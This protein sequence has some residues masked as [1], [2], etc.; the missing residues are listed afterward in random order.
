MRYLEY[1]EF[2]LVR[3]S[4]A[5]RERLWAMA[6]HIIRP[7]R[8]VLPQTQSPR[9]AWMVRLGLFLY[10]HIGGRKRL[11]KTKT[12]ALS[13]AAEGDGL[14][15]RKGRGFIYSDCWVDDARLVVLN[16]V[17]AKALGARIHTRTKFLSASRDGAGWAVRLAASSGRHTV[18]ARAIVN[19]AGP[20]VS[21][22]V[23]QV[24]NAHP[25]GRVRL[26]KGSHIVVPRL[27]DGPHAYML[28]NPDRRIVF[29]IPYQDQFTLIG[30]TDVPVDEPPQRAQID[31]EEIAYLLDTANRYFTT[32]S[33]RGDIVWT[34]SG[35]RPLFDDQAANVSAVTRDYVLD[36]D[37]GRGGEACLLN[38]FGGKIT[39][40]RRLAEHAMDELG[41]AGA[42]QA[43][44]AGAT[45]PGGE[46]ADFDT[47]LADVC[48]RY[49]RFAQ[50]FLKRLARA[51]GT[52]LHTIIGDAKQIADLGE[53][54]G[55]GLTRAEVDY[56]VANEW[57]QTA[58]DILWRRSKLGL[59]VPEDT[60]D[61]LAA[62]LS[63]G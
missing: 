45:L 47:F 20:W 14:K 10:D 16:A 62:Y 46:F 60:E 25:K 57:A 59:H 21:E 27:F 9:P 63:A 31:D 35:V 51:Y 6:P 23:E 55:G 34:Y 4:L 22:V 48:D 54:F 36:L 37:R 33:G 41:L 53:D 5:E 7:M 50:S 43:W 2:R 15:D 56:L 24:E 44:T 1:G 26:I 17:D 18:E 8:F 11:P 13:S 32:Q 38:V 61:R 39:T 19:T 40:F 52:R 3:E 58:Q 42:G 49:P 30:T 28:Q 29:A 12:V